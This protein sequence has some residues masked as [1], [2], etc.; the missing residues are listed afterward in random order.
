[1]GPQGKP[2]RIVDGTIRIY[3]LRYEE[4]VVAYANTPDTPEL[5]STIVPLYAFKEEE[6]NRGLEMAESIAH[7]VY[8]EMD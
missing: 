1:L 5:A 8:E 3:V 4:H 7:L 2:E 6:W